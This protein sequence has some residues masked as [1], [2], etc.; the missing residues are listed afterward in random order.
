MT[1]HIIDPFKRTTYLRSNESYPSARS[2]P[3]CFLLQLTDSNSYS[4][5]LSH[6]FIC[7]IHGGRSLRDKGKVSRTGFLCKGVS[8]M[9]PCGLTGLLL[10]PWWARLQH[11]AS[12][13]GSLL[14]SII[15]LSQTHTRSRNARTHTEPSCR[16]AH[17][18][19]C[20]RHKQGRSRQHRQKRRNCSSLF[21]C[22]F[23]LAFSVQGGKNI[24]G[25]QI[26]RRVLEKGVKL[27]W[28]QRNSE[29][30]WDEIG[31]RVDRNESMAE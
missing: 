27:R 9:S 8:R 7:N 4:N 26:E 30:E 1:L 16:L 31:G 29:D 15:V 22:L 28:K 17:M 24:L 14:L 23:F 10:A 6:V 3:F 19:S 18:S 21:F 11:Y 5:F 25:V 13:T 20:E 2:H 12:L